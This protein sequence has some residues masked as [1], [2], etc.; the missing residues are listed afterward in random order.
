[1]K[2]KLFCLLLLL[3]LPVCLLFTGC[4][5]K[6]KNYQDNS[7]ERFVFIEKVQ[8][9]FEDEENSA[10]DI[11]IAVDKETKIM[12]FVLWGYEKIAIETMLDK[13]GKPLI[14]KGEL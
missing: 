11:Y 12:Y 10:V 5:T 4:G 6:S 13:D 2:K 9:N 14:Y 3:V 7:Y 8:D 1:M